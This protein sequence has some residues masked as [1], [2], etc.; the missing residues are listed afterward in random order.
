MR[1]HLGLLGERLPLCSWIDWPPSAV[2]SKSRLAILNYNYDDT[3]EEYLTRHRV[4][5]RIVWER[6]RRGDQ[7]ARPV[8]HVHGY[9]KRG[10]GPTTPLMLAEEEYHE[11]TS[12]PFSWANLVQ[13]TLLSSTTCLFI[14]NSL[15]DPNLRRLLRLSF[16]ASN[17][18][19]YAFLPAGDGSETTEM[20][21]ALFDGDLYRVG[22]RTIRYPL[23]PDPASA[24]G[25]L[26]ELIDVLRLSL[27]DKHA[28]WTNS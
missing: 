5:F 28:L 3:F 4:R 27:T 21:N 15:T 24:H 18:P 23:R 17:G 10:G 8:Y 2:K 13:T 16:K 1:R 22:L 26:A 9:L 7:R 12:A 11:E 25:R 6:S 20:Y 19:H 14:G